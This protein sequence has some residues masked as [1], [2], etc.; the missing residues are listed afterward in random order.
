[1]RSTADSPW[2]VGMVATRRSIGRP[3]TI[4][5]LR[6]SWGSRRSEMS[7]SAMIFSRLMIPARSEAGARMA[8]WSTPSM[9]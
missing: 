2:M 8:S 4:M 5:A 3:A 9:R 6:P 1:M 7:M